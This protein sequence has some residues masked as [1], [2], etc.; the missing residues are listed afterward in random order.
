MDIY[1]LE[2]ELRKLFVSYGPTQ[3]MTSWTK[4]V[5]DFRQALSDYDTKPPTIVLNNVTEPVMK[6]PIVIPEKKSKA[7]SP[8][9]EA[10]KDKLRLHKEAIAKKRQELA[11]L[12]IIPETQLTEINLSRWIETEKK[13]YWT[14]AEET[15][16]NDTDISAK[17]KSFNIM[18]D[19]A[20][21]IRFKRRTQI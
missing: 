14:I 9:K 10:Q 3:V 7:Q 19:V 17:A 4:V 1:G 15:G 2:Q 21:Y 18:S 5:S 12:G 8:D 11:A 20:K 13:N 6:N 16:C